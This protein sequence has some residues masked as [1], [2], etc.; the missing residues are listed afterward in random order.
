MWTAS[1]RVQWN[2]LDISKAKKIYPLSLHFKHKIN[3]FAATLMRAALLMSDEMQETVA[4][5]DGPLCSSPKAVE[6]FIHSFTLSRVSNLLLESRD[7]SRNIPFV[8]QESKTPG[9]IKLSKRLAPRIGPEK[10][11]SNIWLFQQPRSLNSG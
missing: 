9:A 3:D 7:A 4:V 8:L 6:F 2:S 10:M 5:L 1:F 11:P